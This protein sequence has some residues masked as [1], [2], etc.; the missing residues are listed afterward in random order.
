MVFA[1]FK[2]PGWKLFCIIFRFWNSLRNAVR[3][4]GNRDGGESVHFARCSCSAGALVFGGKPGLICKET[5]A[6]VEPQGQNRTTN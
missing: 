2:L 6:E 1:Q 5:E 3:F 4:S